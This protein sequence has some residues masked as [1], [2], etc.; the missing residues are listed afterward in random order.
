MGK[1]EDVIL[2]YLSQPEVF[3]DLFN[4]YVFN[5]KQVIESEQLKEM[6]GKAR[7]LLDNDS[8]KQG[9]YEV[10][11]RERDIVR[12]AVIGE[13]RIR[14]MV[15]GVEQQT[16]VDYSMPLRV[17]AYDTLEYLKQAKQIEQGHRKKKDV[18]GKEFLS[19]FTKEDRLI[20]TITILF[21]TGKETWDGAL[22]LSG[23]FGDTGYAKELAPC[24]VKAPLNLISIYD[25][26]YT[27]KYHSSLRKIFEILPFVDS[28]EEL[29]GY[30]DCH[31]EE[32]SSIDSAA[33]RVL[34]L[35][36][37]LE[38]SVKD[39][40]YKEEGGNMCKAIEEIRQSSRAEGLA[41]GKQQI[42]QNMLNKGLSPEEVANLTDVPL[43]TVQSIAAN[44]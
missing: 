27:E 43:E 38:I 36:M 12:E 34:S 4:G 20:P 37:D 1:T 35:L 21:Y 24:M 39:T 33:A 9:T 2:D 30:L 42:I 29:E 31:Q 8:G 16:N 26:K 22:E 23:L 25:V 14:L 3:A 28:K 18:S 6:D 11:R 19:M 7:L 13:Q 40:Q 15:C 17:L 10:V 5:G 41:E 32:Y 44:Q